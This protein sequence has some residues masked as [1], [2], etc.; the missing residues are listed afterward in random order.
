M[1]SG[2]S[3]T[4]I[5]PGFSPGPVGSFAEVC[6]ADQLH[7]WTSE[8]PIANLFVGQKLNVYGMY[9]RD[10]TKFYLVGFQDS[11]NASAFFSERTGRLDPE[12]YFDNGR[13]KILPT[14]RANGVVLKLNG[15]K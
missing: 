4:L 7:I 5:I 15:C 9:T 1:L 14:L 3:A 2:C 11:N 10:M 6:S 8:G 13:L 12:V